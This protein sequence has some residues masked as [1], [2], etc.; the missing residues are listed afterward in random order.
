MGIRE[1]R[2]AFINEKRKQIGM[3]DEEYEKKVKDTYRKI[4]LH[5]CGGVKK[6]GETRDDR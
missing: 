1:A 2:S 5:K 6:E 3:T 4:A